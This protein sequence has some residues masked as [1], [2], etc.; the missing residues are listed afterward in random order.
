MVIFTK[1]NDPKFLALI[2]ELQGFFF[3][4]TFTGICIFSTHFKGILHLSA[5]ENK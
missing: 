5:S 2:Y 1:L 4:N 3:Q